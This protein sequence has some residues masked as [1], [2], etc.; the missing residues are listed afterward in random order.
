MTTV[1]QVLSY[2]DSVNYKDYVIGFSC[3]VYVFEQYLKYV[4]L[5]LL[6]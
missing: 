5:Y 1:D 2:L 6:F 3:T 4:M